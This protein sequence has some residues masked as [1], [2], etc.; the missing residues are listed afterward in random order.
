MYIGNLQATFASPDP[1]PTIRTA[2]S[3]AI[4]LTGA[5][6]AHGRPLILEEEAGFPPPPKEAVSVPFIC[7]FRDFGC[8]LCRPDLASQWFIVLPP[9]VCT[10][11]EPG[12]AMGG[13]QFETSTMAEVHEAK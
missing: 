2:N 13:A 5:P 9:Q 10:T 4:T 7:N 8:P 3:K 6:G 1:T 12:Q 11:Q